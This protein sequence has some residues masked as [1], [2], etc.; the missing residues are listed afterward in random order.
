MVI[1]HSYVSLP[2]GTVQLMM[3]L[4]T[5]LWHCVFMVFECCSLPWIR[6]RDEF[7]PPGKWTWF[8]FRRQHFV[9]VPLLLRDTWFMIRML[10][11]T[12][13]ISYKSRSVVG[14][15]CFN[16]SL[17]PQK[18]QKKNEKICWFPSF[19][20]HVAHVSLKAVG[21]AKKAG[22]LWSLRSTCCKT[23]LKKTHWWM[24]CGLVWCYSLVLMKNHEWFVIWL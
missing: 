4:R 17:I 6:P 11:Y 18:S 20:Y 7:K 3:F 1:F 24:I 12:Y 15:C 2:E 9:A 8:S 13:T 23:E 10:L 16:T 14:S 5:D 21:L 19:P 22:A